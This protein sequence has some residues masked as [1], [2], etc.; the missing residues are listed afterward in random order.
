MWGW[1]QGQVMGVQCRAGAGE[2]PGEKGD[3]DV[4]W[5]PG[6]GQGAAEWTGQQVCQWRGG[7]TGNEP[8]QQNL[9]LLL[10]SSLLS[11]SGVT[12]VL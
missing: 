2:A 5:Q 12:D 11:L 10:F 4:S 9:L 1:S 7:E 8:Q 6:C 3:E